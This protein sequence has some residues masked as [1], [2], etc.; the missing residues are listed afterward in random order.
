MTVDI[1]SGVLF[2]A[3]VELE[4]LA[5]IYNFHIVEGERETRELDF[6]QISVLE[7]AVEEL[8]EGELCFIYGHWDPDDP[9]YYITLYEVP[10]TVD[11]IVRNA[12][13]LKEFPKMIE[14][15]G[16]TPVE[17]RFMAYHNVEY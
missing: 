3:K 13:K 16:L 8:S 2:G 10:V 5:K 9:A 12:G 15:L 7:Q 4:D 14:K 17:G 1:Y 6:D 11:E